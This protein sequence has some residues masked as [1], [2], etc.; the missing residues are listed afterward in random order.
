MTDKEAVED[1]QRFKA[2]L[3]ELRRLELELEDGGKYQHKEN[4]R[5]ETFETWQDIRLHLYTAR[6]EI[7]QKIKAL[8][9]ALEIRKGR[10][11]K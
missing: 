9:D 7:G 1:L 8:Q 3:F 5:Y 10:A 11:R 4:S 2:M 6:E